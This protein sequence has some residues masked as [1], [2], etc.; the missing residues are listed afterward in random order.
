MRID[1]RVLDGRKYKIFLRVFEQLFK[2]ECTLFHPPTGGGGSGRH[3][4][5]TQF[6]GRP[7]IWTKSGPIADQMLV[8]I[9]TNIWSNTHM[10]V[11]IW[12]CG[13]PARPA[14]KLAIRTRIW[15]K[16][17]P[18]SGAIDD[19]TRFGTYEEAWVPLILPY[20][21]LPAGSLRRG[22]PCDKNL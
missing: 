2:L 7:R 1:D 3:L 18:N 16:F 5:W 15:T 10:L 6:L 22:A 9:W 13:S 21:G 12:I 17:G 20:E 19:S 14:T 4:I 8:R 11:Q